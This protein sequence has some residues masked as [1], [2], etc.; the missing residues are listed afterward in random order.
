VVSPRRQCRTALP[1]LRS[2][3]VLSVVAAAAAAQQLEVTVDRNQVSIEEQ[4][5][6]K[7][8]VDG[9]RT[10]PELPP[11]P[12]FRVLERG[13]HEEM[14]FVN[15]RVS[16]SITFNFVLIPQKLGSFEIGAASV[17]ID[18]K[19]ITS[20]PF[21]VKV[22][23]PTEAAPEQAARRDYFLS[24][25]VSNQRPYVGEQ[26]LFTWRFYRRVPVRDARLAVLE[27]GDLVA[28]DMGE[29]R[30]YDTTVNGVQ[31]RVSELRKALFAQRAGTLAI[32]SS[33][34]VI[35]VAGDRRQ[36]LSVFDFGRG[37][38]DQKTLHTQPIELE[39]RALPSAPAGYSGLVG[40]FD[41]EAKISKSQLEVGESAT[42]SLSV[43]GAGNVQMASAPPLPSLPQFKVYDDQP[44][45]TLD[46]TGAK[47]RGTKTYRKALVPLQA[48][49]LEIPA[50][51]LVYFDPGEEAYR[52]A[53]T[54]ALTLD[55]RPAEGQ[56]ELMLTESLSPGGP[57]VAV[58]IL[59]D[60]L[61]PIRR[62]RGVLRA[63][64]LSGWRAWAWG[65]GAAL[66]PAAFLALVLVRRR[67]DRFLL[68]ADLRRRQGA[69]RTVL[70][71][72]RRFDQEGASDP[73]ALAQRASSCLRGYVGDKLGLAGTALT[74]LETHD[75]LRA[76][77]ADEATARRVRE[78]LER[79]EAAQYGVAE[80]S[81]PDRATLV[82]SLDQLCR[83]LD[84][85]LRGTAS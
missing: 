69:L 50:L 53:A 67:R 43:S 77:G 6:L 19:T 2:F 48:G 71:E 73:K 85:Q 64:P 12:E 59:A 7:V 58:R 47:L 54:R 17:E 68:D 62:G 25:Q 31:Y 15:G 37:L 21:T 74:P 9:A 18:G 60:D 84:K 51:R 4:I 14:Q 3:L 52:T 56:E 78:V 16:T 22:V 10:R 70:T 11:L 40:D 32:P 82:R 33:Q 45:G 20:R 65:G 41:L 44:S 83:D 57:K 55:V 8:K 76:A 63:T 42:L 26:V 29:V 27:F 72:L 81:A 23:E 61:L 30:E 28:E 49:Q 39:V 79:C 35:E 46:R 1:V 66:P 75:A 13:H 5:L 38:W 34:L 36:R 80:R 24:A